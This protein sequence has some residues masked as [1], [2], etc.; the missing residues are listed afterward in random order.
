MYKSVIFYGPK[1]MGKTFLS[2]KL[3]YCIQVWFFISVSYV[4]K[5][6]PLII[7]HNSEKY[8]R[9]WIKISHNIADGMLN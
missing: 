5:N 7:L 2:K 8:Q 1:G 6:N 3:A 4:S 9:I